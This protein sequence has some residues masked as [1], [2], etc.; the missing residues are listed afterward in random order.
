MA[1]EQLGASFSWEAIPDL[2]AGLRDASP[3]VRFWCAY[4]VG[5]LRTM[6]AL[7]DLEHLAATDRTKVPGWWTIAREARWAIKQIQLGPWDT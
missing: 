4:A 1:A 6:D 7:P 2:I 5:F 3:E